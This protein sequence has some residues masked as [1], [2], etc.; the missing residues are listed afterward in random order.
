[1]RMPIIILS[2]YTLLAFC[3]TVIQSQYYRSNAFHQKHS[4]N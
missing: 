1:M 4:A 2:C 3:H